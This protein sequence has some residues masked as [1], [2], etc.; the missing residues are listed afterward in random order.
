MPEDRRHERV[1]PRDRYTTLRLSNGR[2]FAARLIDSSMS[3][4]A[5][6]VDYQPP[7]GSAVVVGSTASQVVWIFDNGI[8]VEFLRTISQDQFSHDVTI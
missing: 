4:A 3:G 2:E 8:A 1:P 5:M 6:I 7:I